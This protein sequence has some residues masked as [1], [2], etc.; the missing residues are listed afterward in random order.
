LGEWKSWKMKS[1]EGS[2]N[3]KALMI[4]NYRNGLVLFYHLVNKRHSY[5]FICII[6]P[7]MCEN[8]FYGKALSNFV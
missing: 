5:R 3:P 4:V 8:D 7:W 6:P 2:S 1:N